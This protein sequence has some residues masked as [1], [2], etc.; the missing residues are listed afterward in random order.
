MKKAKK[1]LNP[2]LPLPYGA[3][4]KEELEA[5]TAKFDREFIVDESRPL[6]RK[7]K[8]GLRKA[9]RRRGRPRTGKGARR[10]LVTIERGLLDRSDA[11]ARRKKM[12]RSQ[13]IARGLETVLS[14]AE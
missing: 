12:S 8:T 10:V 5:D 7:L 11:F 9:A 13:L 1:P 3:M 2:K 14:S 6:T 4:S